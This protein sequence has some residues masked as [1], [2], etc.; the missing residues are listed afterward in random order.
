MRPGADP[1]LRVI[2]T[3]L[4][5]AACRLGLGATHHRA[6]KAHPVGATFIG[7][8]YRLNRH[9]RVWSRAR[10]TRAAREGVPVYPRW[11][12]ALDPRPSR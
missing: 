10:Q 4:E 12:T 2:V 8:V 9:A 5:D 7:L 6:T 11:V 3:G 1:C